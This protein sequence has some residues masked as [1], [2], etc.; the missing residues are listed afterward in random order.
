MGIS[1]Y[2]HNTFDDFF[3]SNWNEIFGFVRVYYGKLSTHAHHESSL[4]PVSELVSS[5]S[6]AGRVLV[7]LC[8]FE[9][10]GMAREYDHLFKLLIIGD[11][12]NYDS[13]ICWYF[14]CKLCTGYR[15]QCVAPPTSAVFDFVFEVRVRLRS[16]AANV[17]TPLTD[18]P[19]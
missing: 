15:R 9:D 17:I 12:G 10:I 8:I 4:F 19:S 14:R 7:F 16:R 11:S 1:L 2:E 6:L 3:T 5:A 18:S 13:L